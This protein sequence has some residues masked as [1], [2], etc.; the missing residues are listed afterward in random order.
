M[1]DLPGASVREIVELVRRW[2][3]APDELLAG[4]PV[5]AAELDLPATRVPI[6]VCEAIVARAHALTREPALAFHAGTQMRLSSHG[7][8][9]FAAMTA[10]TARAA[11]ELATH[12]AGTRTS[13]I[14][15]ALYVEGDTASLVIEERTEMSAALRELL[16][17]ALLV[18]IW[19]IGQELTGRA[20]D[21]RGECAFPMPAYARAL[22]LGDRLRFDQPAHRLVFD[23]AILD[24]PLR[25]ADAVAMRL[26]REQCERELAAVVDAGLPARIR[27]V[28]TGDTWPDL[29]AVARELRMSTRTLKRKLAERAT[30][31]SAIRDDVRRQRALLLLA[32]RSLS[33][34][35]VGARLGYGELPNFTRAF[36]RWTGTTPQAYRASLA[37]P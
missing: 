22:P 29:P 20:L 2:S 14:S 27:A 19:Q 18:G 1:A 7:F 3:I 13:A 37:R 31:F 16:V 36:R 6:R 5:R 15:L 30:T 24:V 4:L 32:D 12:F 35:D 9:G 33:I 26:A 28:M 34:G 10:P 25:T 8:L 23:R 17:L 21:G 11:L